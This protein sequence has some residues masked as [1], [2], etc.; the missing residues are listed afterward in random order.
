VPNGRVLRLAV[1]QPGRLGLKFGEPRT[2]DQVV[3]AYGREVLRIPKAVSRALD[4]AV[5][6]SGEPDDVPR[7]RI[8]R[9]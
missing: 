3:R 8:S 6:C 2:D 4:G 5:M 1:R 9:P 7:L